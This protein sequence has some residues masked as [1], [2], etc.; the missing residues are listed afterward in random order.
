M[1]KTTIESIDGK[2]NI[3]LKILLPGTFL[4]R[5][6]AL[7]IDN[8]RVIKFVTGNNSKEFIKAVLIPSSSIKSL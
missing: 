2:K 1:V 5:K 8:G 7:I 4:Y 3:T 6:Y